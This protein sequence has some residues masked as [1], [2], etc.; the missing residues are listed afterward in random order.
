MNP[1]HYKK[2]AGDNIRFAYDWQAEMTRL[3]ATSIDSSTWDL[4]AG[5]VIL[6]ADGRTSF[7]DDS[8]SYAYISG[9]TPDELTQVSNS[10]QFD[11]GDQVVKVFTLAI[12]EG[13]FV[14]S[15]IFKGALD[16]PLDILL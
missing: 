7:T 14:A 5:S 11:T 9:G 8:T 12:K 10:V 1:S 6:G 13:A 3:G 16:A 2:T 15:T 4:V